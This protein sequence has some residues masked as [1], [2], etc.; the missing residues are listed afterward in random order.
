MQ[1]ASTR[2]KEACE[3]RELRT[4]SKALR[5]RVQAADAREVSLRRALRRRHTQVRAR[6]R[7]SLTPS[8]PL[9]FLLPLPHRVR[10]T[11]R[12]P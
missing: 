6:A 1:V 9:P 7:V 4:A 2:L 12:Q 3:A 8:L 5:A 10:V 11:V